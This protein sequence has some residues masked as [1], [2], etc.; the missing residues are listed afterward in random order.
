MSFNETYGSD[1]RVRTMPFY[2]RARRVIMIREQF[3][4]SE[5]T[6]KTFYVLVN[7]MS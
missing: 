5:V 7:R 6:N 3:P 1:F 2:N 4:N